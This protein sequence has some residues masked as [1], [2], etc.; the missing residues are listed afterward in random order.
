[1][2]RKCSFRYERIFVQAPRN[3]R[4]HRATTDR[5]R[6]TQKRVA[7]VF[8]EIN[9]THA[10]EFSCLCLLCLKLRPFHADPVRSAFCA[11]IW[12]DFTRPSAR[13]VAA[14]R[15]RVTPIS[16]LFDS[17]R[18]QCGWL[19]YATSRRSQEDSHHRFWSNRHRPGLRV[20]L[21]WHTGLQ[22]AARRG[23]RGRTRELEPG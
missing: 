5:Q 6:E 7:A 10:L 13:L 3:G 8:N 21:L 12:G 22:S 20:R 17:A 11:V 18:P 4:R 15:P 9:W 14:F 1:M 19:N 23:L 16:L 2:A